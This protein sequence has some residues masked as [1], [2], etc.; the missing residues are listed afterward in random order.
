MW[1]LSPVVLSSFKVHPARETVSSPS[2]SI[3][4]NSSFSFSGMF[5][6]RGLWLICSM[7]I[8]GESFT[9]YVSKESDISI[10]R[11]ERRPQGVL[12]SGPL[13]HRDIPSPAFFRALSFTVG[14][15]SCFPR[16]FL[17]SDT[18]VPQAGSASSSKW[19]LLSSVTRRESGMP[20][21]I[22]RIEKQSCRKPSHFYGGFETSPRYKSV[23]R[24]VE[25]GLLFRIP[26]SAFLK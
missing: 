17:T 16:K 2:F 9:Q 23:A 6:P 22:S 21:A 1:R 3:T 18:N 25:P 5:F 10:E 7:I 8:R 11:C 4:T 12:V 15:S 14:T 26:S 13:I 24:Q 20:V 19:F